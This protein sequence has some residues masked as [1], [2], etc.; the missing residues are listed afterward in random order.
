MVVCLYAVVVWLCCTGFHF[1]LT[2]IHSI[3]PNFVNPAEEVQGNEVR[4]KL[5]NA[6]QATLSMLYI[7]WKFHLNG[8]KF[9]E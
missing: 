1:V 5:I 4:K 3:N 2:F 8:A 6:T 7:K 9:Q